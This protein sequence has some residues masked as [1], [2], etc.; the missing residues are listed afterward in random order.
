M[1][2]VVSLV[3]AVLAAAASFYA[4][5][6]LLVLDIEPVYDRESWPGLVVA[7]A[8][9]IFLAVWYIAYVLLEGRFKKDSDDDIF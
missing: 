8:L 9:P 4:A 7:V 5:Y 6:Y 3:V 1:R 2:I